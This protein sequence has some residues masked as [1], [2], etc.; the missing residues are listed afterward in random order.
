MDSLDLSSG[1]LRLSTASLIHSDHVLGVGVDSETD[2]LRLEVKDAVE[3]TQK[4]VSKDVDVVVLLVKR[5]LCNRELADSLA[6]MQVSLWTHLKDSVSNMEA[7][8]LE[9]GSSCLTS[10]H[11]LTEDLLTTVQLDCTLPLLSESIELISRDSDER[12]ASVDDGSI[13][14][15][16]LAV[17]KRHPVV[18]KVFGRKSPRLDSTLVVSSIVPKRG[19]TSLTTDNLRGVVASKEGV[20]LVSYLAV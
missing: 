18:H 4:Q 10:A 6:L 12:T 13:L 17:A 8:W 1:L 7:N 11:S 9:F 2:E 20:W 16:L 14:L 15:R 5:V 19:K 3:V